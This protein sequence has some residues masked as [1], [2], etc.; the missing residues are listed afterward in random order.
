MSAMLGNLV[1]GYLS[2]SYGRQRSFVFI[3]LLSSMANISLSFSMSFDMVLF[4]T[5][6]L[7]I[8]VGGGLPTDGNLFLESIPPNRESLL[9]L[10]SC[11]W[12]VGQFGAAVLAIFLMP[13][14]SCTNNNDHCFQQH[15]E[16][17]SWRSLCF[18]TGIFSFLDF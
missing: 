2:D 18:A 5:F 15:T 7:G 13:I 8:G 9:A 1:F 6:L 3:L 17:S 10:L 14:S 4:S 11:F 12:P 16:N